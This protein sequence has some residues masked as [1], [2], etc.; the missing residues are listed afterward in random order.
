MSSREFVLPRTP[1]EKIVAGVFSATLNVDQVGAEDNFFELGGHSLLA[2][3]VISRLREMLKVEVPLR[4]LFEAPTV[5]ELSTQIL[6]R[7]STTGQT[8]KIARII[9]RLHDANS[10]PAT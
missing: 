10:H 4:S 7:E 3:Q 8:E 2:M 5:A 6:A 9:M 1:I